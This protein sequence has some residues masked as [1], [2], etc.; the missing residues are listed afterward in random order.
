MR[1]PWNPMLLLLLLTTAVGQ[2]QDDPIEAD[3]R[4]RLSSRFKRRSP[5]RGSSNVSTRR[6]RMP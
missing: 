3:R 4:Q 5:I 6:W 1:Q 2:A